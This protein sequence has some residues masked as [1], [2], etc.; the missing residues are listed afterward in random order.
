MASIDPIIA[1]LRSDQRLVDAGVN[2]YD[3]PPSV[4]SA[5][6]VV[7]RPDSPW[8]APSSWCTVAGRWL[9]LACVAVSADPLW[10]A[11]EDL[12]AAVV[13]VAGDNPAWRWSTTDPP[14][15][16]ESTSSALVIAAIH[17]ETDLTQ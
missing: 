9:A 15:L 1:A 5:P 6:A 3:S 7:F 12:A 17:I 10:D 8:M 13:D 2:V 14:V 16:D 4:L 11:L